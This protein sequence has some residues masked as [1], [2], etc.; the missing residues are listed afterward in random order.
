MWNKKV[1]IKTRGGYSHVEAYRDVPP[2]RVVFS[3]GILRQGSHVV[4]KSLD[5]GPDFRK[6]AK[7]LK[8]SCQISRFEAEKPL[9]KGPDFQNFRK[10]VQISRFLSE[11]N[12]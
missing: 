5:K 6:I 10:N 7:I 11:K 12:P 2:K 9:E 1:P 3:P 4:N 8:K